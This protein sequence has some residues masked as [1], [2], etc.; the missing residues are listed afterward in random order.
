VKPFEADGLRRIRYWCQRVERSGLTC[1]D[2]FLN[3][4]DTW[5]DGIANYFIDHQTSSFVEGLNNKLKV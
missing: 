3:L 5:G 4:L 1:F 2:R